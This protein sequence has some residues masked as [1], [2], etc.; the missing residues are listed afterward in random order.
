M[1]W[2]LDLLIWS[3]MSTWLSF[4]FQVF[5]C[6][7]FVCSFLFSVLWS[8]TLASNERETCHTN[9]KE[10]NE[11]E[12]ESIFKSNLG[13]VPEADVEGPNHEC[14]RHDL[15][16]ISLPL[17]CFLIVSVFRFYLDHQE[18]HSCPVFPAVCSLW[19]LFLY[20]WENETP[21]TE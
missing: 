10:K 1:N 11:N 5:W 16:P 13:R 4:N 15:I 18:G 21:T 6:F 2:R 17:L 12:E 8:F 9:V 3:C 7:C 14:D 20:V 19:L